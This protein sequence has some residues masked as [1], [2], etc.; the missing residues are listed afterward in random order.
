[1]SSK[2]AP[3]SDRTI[4]LA[5]DLTLR[6]VEQTRRRLLDDMV[7][8]HAITIDCADD[9][10]VDMTFLQVI[11]AARK[12]AQTNG[13]ELR[14]ARPAPVPVRMLLERAGLIGDDGQARAE[15]IDFWTAKAT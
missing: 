9:A 8:G 2:N 15:D 14:L 3:T 5:G 13:I 7:E 1:M 10:T 6:T 12:T 4:V 11:I